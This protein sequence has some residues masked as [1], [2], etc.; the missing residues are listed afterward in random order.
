VPHPAARIPASSPVIA[1]LKFCV[2]ARNSDMFMPSAR[3][4]CA[5]GA[6]CQG[7]KPMQA[8]RK[9]SQRSWKPPRLDRCGSHCWRQGEMAIC[10][11]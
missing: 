3:S 8:T 1:R 5:I 9:R 10:R 6:D 2:V 7:S 4:R 11:P